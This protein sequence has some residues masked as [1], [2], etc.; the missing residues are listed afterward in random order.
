MKLIALMLLTLS[1]FF[2]KAS[3]KK[4]PWSELKI[5]LS[6]QLQSYEG[7]KVKDVSGFSFNKNQAKLKNANALWTCEYMKN[8]INN[9]SS[10]SYT[11]QLQKGQAAATGVAL[12]FVFDEWNE[13][14]YVIMP[15]AAYNANRFEVIKYTY[16]PLFKKE[17]YKEDMPITITDVPRLN[18]YDGKSQMDLNTGDLTTPAIGVYFPETQKGIWILTEQT[19]ELGNSVLSLKEN[20]DRTKAEFTISAPCVREMVYGMTKLSDSDE[21][22]VDW[23]EGDKATIKCKVFVFEDINSP[24]ELNNQFLTVRKSFGTTNHV[25]QLP[26]S[27]AFKIMEK[28]QNLECWDEENKYYSMGGEGWNSKWQLG[29]VGGCM[30]TYPLSL[31]GH[32]LSQERSFENYQRI[33]MKTQAKSGFYYSCSNGKGW[34]SDCFSKPFSDNLLLL[35]KN[36]DALYYFYKYCFA[37]KNI[38]PQWQMPA[39]WKKPLTK[40][41][42]AF[43][44]LWNRYGQF[45]QFIDMETGEIKVGGTNSAVMA[46]GGLALASQF[47]NRPELLQTAKEAARYYYNNFI[48]KGISCGGPSEILQNNDS[49]SC[50]ATLESF[51][52]LYEVTGEKEWLNYAED[53]AALCATWTVSYD[54]KFPSASL[55]GKL[56]MRTTGSVWASTQNKHGGPGICTMSGDCLFKLYRYT[57]NKIYLELTK[58][59]AHNIM[60]YMSREDRPIARLHSGW[61]NERVNLSD[62]EGKDN[63]GNLFHGNTWA[64]VSA[65]LTVTEIPGIYV[66]PTKKELSVFDHVNAKLEGNQ[67]K[68]TNPTKFD[69]TIKIFVDRD[70]SKTYPQ[71]FMS[72]CPKVEVKAGAS[73]IYEL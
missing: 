24:A 65:M 30:V 59:I 42:D 3:N 47:E 28:Q 37:Q 1:C 45:G 27:E 52:A 2:V 54:Y 14:N 8:S 56:D 49:E 15:G 68:I 35:R 70:P 32:T 26:F 21:T 39:E 71:G 66:N 57:G 69:A 12:N 18:K 5:K 13:E 10:L 58:D 50:F 11:F 61:I 62:W 64:Q 67:I 72:Q 7:N 22:G 44:T 38:N 33:I 63:V 6:A 40:F 9:S 73:I 23:Q 29:W 51:I 53:A 17:K 34:C 25:D 36:A 20:E 43:V 55:F 60:Q 19:T 46:I 4:D 41:A 31:D 16:P 48:K